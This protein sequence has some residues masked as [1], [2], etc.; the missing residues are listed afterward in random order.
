MSKE[1]NTG[2]RQLERL[3]NMHSLILDAAGE[4]VY[5]L[6][7]NGNTTFVNKA[8]ERILGWRADDVVGQPLHDIHHHSHADGSPYPREECPIYAAIRDGQV[9]QVDHEV[10]WRTDGS[11]VPVEYTSTPIIEDGGIC[12]AVVVFRDIT[13]RKEMERQREAAYQQIKYLKEMLEQERDYLRDE[14]NINANFGEIIGDSQALKRT[15]AQIEA[16]AA[17]TA[18]VLVNGE[19]GV[20]KEMIARAIHRRSPRAGAPLVKVNCASIPRELFES[21]FFGHVKGAFT[22]AHKDR[23]GR[24][25]LANGGTLFL[26]E[27]GE[28]PPE[29]QGKLLRALQEGEFE[30]VGDEQTIKV[31][32]RVVAATNRD[33]QAGVEAGN[34]RQ[35]LFYRLCVF[36]I[37]VPPLRQRRSDIVPLAM[38][39]IGLICGELGKAPLTLT[40]R[41]AD[42]LLAHHWPGN[43]R[44]LKNVIERAVIL[45]SGD[46]LRLDL[47]MPEI[48]A[49]RERTANVVEPDRDFQTETER[50]EHE[51]E[52]LLRV[53]EASGW[54]I[55]GPGGAAERLG[56]KPSTLAYRIKVFAIEKSREK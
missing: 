14:I 38:H 51:R 13:A 31:D 26:D 27:V 46:R 53:L 17:T 37:D 3:E 54:K 24:M 9:H 12:G 11:S 48:P 21:E 16:V 55:S 44:E 20:G 19:S 34:F 33:L 22:G 36:P 32:V 18:S 47:A 30:R 56:V 29:Q 2:T 45:S 8:A 7:A 39:F 35:D 43:V 1:K 6:D 41:G 50:R 4:G 23:V 15:F 42:S 25:Q 5:G 49:G 28:I 40:Q 10:F 52:N